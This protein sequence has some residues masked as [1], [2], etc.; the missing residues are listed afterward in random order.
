MKPYHQR[1]VFEDPD[2]SEINQM[3]Q[4][5]KFTPKKMDQSFF[6][7][8]YSQIITFIRQYI[9]LTHTVLDEED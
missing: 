3:F 7:Y 4:G 5:T 2:L 9:W 1:S 8:Q 6:E